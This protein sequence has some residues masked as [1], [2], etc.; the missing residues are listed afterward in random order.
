MKLPTIRL[1]AIAIL[2]FVFAVLFAASPS[3]PVSA[4]DL[5]S[6]QTKADKSSTVAP[7]TV[8][9]NT[10][11]PIE[12]Q[13]RGDWVRES[14]GRHVLNIKVRIF[15]PTKELAGYSTGIERP[16]INA[17]TGIGKDHYARADV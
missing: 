11:A 9:A 4:H 1:F 13:A 14:V 17:Y 16:K 3:P 6:T 15:E 2:A 10:V 8:D 12:G 5:A 7:T